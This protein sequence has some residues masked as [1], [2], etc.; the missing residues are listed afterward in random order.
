[1]STQYIL[2]G[3]PVW[4][5]GLG[6]EMSF[7]YNS[8]ITA[9]LNGVEFAYEFGSLGPS[10]PFS[11][12]C[13]P[14]N[15]NEG[16]ILR[17]TVSSYDF[18]DG[19]TAL[20]SLG[21]IWLLSETETRKLTDGYPA[22]EEVPVFPFTFFDQTWVIGPQPDPDPDQV[23]RDQI[24]DPCAGLAHG[25]A[26]A[27]AALQAA[28]V[29]LSY[30][31]I[32]AATAPA[33]MGWGWTMTGA[34]SRVYEDVSNNDMVLRSDG[35]EERWGKLPDDSYAPR[36]ANNY[37]SLEVQVSG[38]VVITQKNKVKQTFRA[39][40]GKLVTEVDRNGNTITYA[41]DD[42]GS[43][44]LISITDGE[45]RGTYFAYGSRTDGQP[46]EI[47]SQ[48]P[49][50]GRLTTLEYDLDDRLKKVTDPEGEAW[51]YIYDGNG[52]LYQIKDPR[53]QVATEYT[54]DS[55]KMLTET[56]YGLVQ[57]TYAYSTGPNGEMVTTVTEEDLTLTPSDPNPRVTEYTYNSFSKLVKLVDPL[58]NEFTFEY[59]DPRNPYLLTLQRDPN[60]H[61]TTFG[62]D[63]FGN[64]IWVR[65]AQGN[66][67]FFDYTE[68][69]LL[70]S[71]LPPPVTV[72]GGEEPTQYPP[73][74]FA[75]DSSGNLESI[76]ETIDEVEVTRSYEVDGTGRVIS[77]TDC[78]G[79]VTEFTYTTY[80]A[81]VSNAG[82][83]KTITPPDGPGTDP[84]M[85]TTFTY[86][87][88]DNVLTVTDA[89]DNSIEYQYDD[90]D[91][92]KKIFYDQVGGMTEFR[93]TDGL[94]DWVELPSLQDSL[95]GSSV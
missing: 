36:W 71:I 19:P 30:N 92:V 57:K 95:S 2:C 87:L 79:K 43:G 17:I 35:F 42:L 89:L 65:D 64:R 51:E 86:D 93:Y 85:M 11:E 1:M 29:S 25:L 53:G 66:T 62:Y 52:L 77:Y 59:L 34:H 60:G 50:V 40:D 20:G 24:C 68:G 70:S 45:G 7:R 88:Y 72:H 47:R 82:N 83:L 15:A 48:D 76:T 28:G 3:V 6:V 8:I 54:Y 46:T 69:Y 58:E 22:R 32:S 4:N 78:R 31:A 74:V 55:G 84:A 13:A 39:G 16:D 23:K 61:E 27:G 44:E 18:N 9:Y 63:E 94:L 91:R 56:S 67:T 10:A 12:S 33:S 49:I 21:P 90:K 81:G 26:K 14:F 41:Y 38:D 80:S 73:V 75:Y 37:A 5:D